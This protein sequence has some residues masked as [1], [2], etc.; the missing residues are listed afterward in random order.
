[1]QNKADVMLYN[2]REMKSQ[3]NYIVERLLKAEY[4]QG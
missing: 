4:R 2:T 1:M 3:G